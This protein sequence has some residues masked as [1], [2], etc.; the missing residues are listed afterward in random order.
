LTPWRAH[1]IMADAWGF[2]Y[3]AHWLRTDSS[4]SSERGRAS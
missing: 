2:T 3:R 1:L 4:V